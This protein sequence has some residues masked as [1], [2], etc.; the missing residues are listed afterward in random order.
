VKKKLMIIV[1]VVVLLVGAVMYKMVLSAPPA[2][3]KTKVTGTLVTL[4]DPFLV[5]L[6]GGHYGKVTVAL[7]LSA[8]PTAAAD[9]AVTLP[10]QAAVRS[11]V[12]DELTGIEPARL[13]D[14]SARHDLVATLLKALHKQTDEPITRVYLTDIT[15]Q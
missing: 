2:K 1:P 14:A 11:V 3:A 12:T 9:G 13:V 15:V 5:N 7:L 6:A 4:S 8:A 10:E